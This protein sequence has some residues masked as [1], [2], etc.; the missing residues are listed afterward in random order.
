MKRK[1]HIKCKHCKLK[2]DEHLGP[3][4]SCPLGR[5]HRTLGYT[6]SH[7]SNKYTPVFRYGY[8]CHPCAVGAGLTWESGH[9]ATA[10]YNIC[11]YCL[12]N[13]SLCAVTDWLMPRQKQLTSWD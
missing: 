12:K 4:M 2:K 10:H 11:P 6:S 3:Q 13:E 9:C 1:A 7:K 5:K 8:I